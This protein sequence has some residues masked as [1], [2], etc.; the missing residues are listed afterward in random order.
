MNWPKSLAFA[1]ISGCLL[2][3]AFPQIDLSFFAWIGFVPLLQLIQEQTPKRAFLF[4]WTAGMGFYLCTVYWVVHT[5]GLYS[6]IP[7]LIAVGPLFMMCAILASYTG[8]FA[9]GL[10]LSSNVEVPF[11]SSVRHCGLPA[12]GSAPFSSSASRGSTWD[13]HNTN[14]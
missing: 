13:I 3:L 10:P 11:F 1:F 7:P 2:A 12:N 4:G 8:L 14:I 5:I 6:N 9:A